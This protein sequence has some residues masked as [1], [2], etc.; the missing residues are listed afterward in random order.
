ML[1]KSRIGP[2]GIGTPAPEIG[3][4]IFS[5]SAALL[6]RVQYCFC[7]SGSL[8]VVIILSHVIEEGVQDIQGSGLLFQ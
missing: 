7:R 6:E 4:V 3:N 1:V 2:I 5:H 8:R